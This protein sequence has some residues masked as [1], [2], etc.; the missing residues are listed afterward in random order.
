MAVFRYLSQIRDTQNTLKIEWQA[1]R[2]IA[3]RLPGLLLFLMEQTNQV[4]RGKMPIFQ[5]RLPRYAAALRGKNCVRLHMQHPSPRYV[6]AI[7]RNLAELQRAIHNRDAMLAIEAEHATG[8][9]LLRLAYLALYNDYMAHAMKVFEEGTRV[10]SFWYLYRTDQGLAD[11]FMRTVSIDIASISDMSA[12][13]KKIR[14]ATHF[15]IDADARGQVL[16]GDDHAVLGG[17][18]SERCGL[19]GADEAREAHAYGAGGQQGVEEGSAAKG[20][21]RHHGQARFT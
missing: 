18:G 14:D 2:A 6:H 10:A 5:L 21:A 13:L 7:E 9:A 4:G 1:D 17:H 8:Y 3:S 11:S 16:R 15:H 12:R 19:G 20:E